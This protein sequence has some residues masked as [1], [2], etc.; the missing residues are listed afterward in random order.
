MLQISHDKLIEHFNSGLSSNDVAKI[1]NVH[2]STIQRKY[3]LAGLVYKDSIQVGDEFE[4]LKILEDCGVTNF[5]SKLDRVYN[6]LCKCGNIKKCRRSRLVDGRNTSC[7]CLMKS[8]LG[9]RNKLPDLSVSS[10]LWERIK[11]NAKKRNLEFTITKKYILD[12]F[13]GQSKK[14]AITGV[15]LKLPVRKEDNKS[16]NLASLDRI[17]NTKGYVEGNVRWLLWKVN[18][19]KWDMTDD[20]LYNICDLIIR[21]KN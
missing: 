2:A 1:Y 3:K 19:M 17:D 6:C 8:H 15:E 7:G 4:N 20:E 16:E 12:V 21:N 5:S 13:I 11:S 18:R 14:C 9:A 10:H